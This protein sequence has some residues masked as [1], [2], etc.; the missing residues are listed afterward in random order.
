MRAISRI[1]AREYPD[2][3][4]ASHGGDD[5]P[6]AGLLAAGADRTA[7]L[8][9]GHACPDLTVAGSQPPGRRVTDM[10]NIIDRSIS[11]G[12]GAEVPGA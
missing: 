8:R 10:S 2:L 12:F 5:D 11:F 4:H 6:L 9:P 7:Q 1:V 3:G